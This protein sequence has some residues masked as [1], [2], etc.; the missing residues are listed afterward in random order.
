MKIESSCA[1][2]NV[3][4]Q[5]YMF[6]DKKCLPCFTLQEQEKRSPITLVQSM[7][8]LAQ[9]LFPKS[10]TGSPC[11]IQVMNYIIL[12]GIHA[13]PALEILQLLDGF[14]SCLHLCKKLVFFASKCK[15]VAAFLVASDLVGS[16]I[17]F[18]KNSLY[19]MPWKI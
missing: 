19:W 9:K 16:D 13:A 8:I 17:I 18:I 12:D 3:F 15:P 10:S 14:L 1:I 6:D 5:H 7:W 4:W 2:V 11:L